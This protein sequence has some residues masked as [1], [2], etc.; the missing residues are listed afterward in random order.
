MVGWGS[1]SAGG[2][3][4]Q[5]A[6]SSE[7]EPQQLRQRREEN[8]PQQHSKFKASLGYQRH[9]L[10]NKN[11]VQ[12]IKKAKVFCNHQT[13]LLNSW[14][15]TEIQ[16]NSTVYANRRNR[17]LNT[18]HP[19]ARTKRYPSAYPT[20]TRH[21]NWLLHSLLTAIVTTVTSLSHHTKQAQT[22]CGHL[23]SLQLL[24]NTNLCADPGNCFSC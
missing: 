18:E 2:V 24:L 14:T 1:S 23:S 9:Y 17:T 15:K 4:T 12:E 22:D 7:C 10:K 21:H 13:L 8:R 20:S 6:Q 5:H 19:H 3:L 16:D 11:V